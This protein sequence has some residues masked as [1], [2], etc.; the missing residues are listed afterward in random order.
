MSEYPKRIKELKEQVQQAEMKM[1][2]QQRRADKAEMRVED[3]DHRL[4]K[5]DVPDATMPKGAGNMRESFVEEFEYHT[6]GELNAKEKGIL[7]E[8]LSTYTEKMLKG[9]A[10]LDQLLLEQTAR[11]K[12]IAQLSDLTK[13]NSRL[14]ENNTILREM[15]RELSNEIYRMSEASLKQKLRVELLLDKLDESKNR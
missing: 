2:G 7:S 15:V 6:G 3:L 13:E 8:M 11:N 1:R 5:M 9:H 14:E 10:L 4:K 12:A